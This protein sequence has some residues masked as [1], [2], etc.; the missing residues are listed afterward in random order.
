[1]LIILMV[2]SIHQQLRSGATWHRSQQD[3]S[4]GSVIAMLAA[5][6]AKVRTAVSKLYKEV[7]FALVRQVSS[8]GSTG[9][10]ITSDP[11]QL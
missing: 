7:H 11:R 3:G 5:K 2:S 8:A 10:I 9:A 6:Q 1:M 4:H